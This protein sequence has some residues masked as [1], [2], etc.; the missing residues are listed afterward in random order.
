ML[1]RSI[2]CAGGAAVI[3]ANTEEDEDDFDNVRFRAESSI[4]MVMVQASDAAVR[5]ALMP[6]ILASLL[7]LPLLL[8]LLPVEP[9]SMYVHV[10]VLQRLE[11][12]KDVSLTVTFERPS[13]VMSVLGLGA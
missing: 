1:K 8:Q 4:H 9:L 10:H 2:A 6:F 11:A 5:S 12:A 3:V 13:Q 7:P